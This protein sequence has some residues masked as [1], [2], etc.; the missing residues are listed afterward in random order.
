MDGRGPRT[1][2]TVPKV[3]IGIPT[4]NRV[5]Y[6]QLA[7]ESAFAQ[8]Y[9]NLEIIVSDNASHDGTAKFLSGLDDSRLRVIS[10]ERRIPMIQNWNT[11][12][13]AATG[14]FFLLLSDDDI[15]RATAVEELVAG[16]LN[17]GTEEDAVGIVYC[18]GYEID[19]VGTVIRTFRH[20]PRKESAR[21]LISAFFN[22][23]RDLWFCAILF[24]IGDILSGFSL[25]YKVSSDSAALI[26]ATIRH[27]QAVFVPRELVCYRVHQNAT[28]STPY[29]VWQKELVQL[30]E[31]AIAELI[32]AGDC[33][34]GYQRELRATVRR[35]SIS[36]ISHRINLTFK[37]RKLR[38]LSEYGRQLRH[39][40]SPVGMVVLARGL[41]S[42]FATEKVKAV[43]KAHLPLKM[44]QVFGVTEVS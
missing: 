14:E 3:T 8:S 34:V 27:G 9:R 32:M 35:L 18:G 1:N 16:Y 23:E 30:C 21:R 41:F 25:D 38:A 43:V 20:S 29:G 2:T 4:L 26:Q 10:Q 13:F 39:F 40:L 36:M 42:L 15:L 33:D 28:N 22:S 37:R 31:L 19:S 17:E 12:V 24:R 5:G 6:L 44:Q 11:C 7:L